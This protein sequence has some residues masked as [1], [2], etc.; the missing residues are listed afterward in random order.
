MMSKFK[1]TAVNPDGSEARG[2]IEGETRTAAGL[3]LLERDLQITEMSEHKSILQFELIRKKVPRKDLMQFSR[4]MAVFLRAG[5]P[6]T[7]ALDIIREEAP[8]KS[9]FAAVLADMALALRG[10]A[11]FTESAMAHPEAFPPFYLGVLEAAEMTGNLDTALEEVAVYIERDLEARRK[12]QSALFYPAVVFLMSIATVLILTTFVLPRFKTF[13][14]DMHAKLPLPTRMLLSMTDFLTRDWPFVVGT[15]LIIGCVIG[16][17]PRTNRGRDIRD[18]LLLKT[19]VI[20]GLIRGAII[21]RF[22]RTL[23]SMVRSGVS[24]PDALVVTSDGTNNVIYRRGLEEVRMSMLQGEGLAGPIARTGLFPGA[25]RQM[26]RVGEETGTLD[27]QLETS[28]QYFASDLDFKIARFTNLFEPAVILFMGLVVGFVAI[29]LVS[30]M[31][32]IFNQV[33]IT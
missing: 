28:A 17:G 32:G 25:A 15:L 26:I 13:F 6:V 20:G 8:P 19:P 18:T 33:N 21:E 23:S 30:A 4:Q 29:A 11:T 14:S 22:C 5:I 31:Y 24:L 10:G 3:A 12:I 7:D 2:V 16:F 1:Y 9:L 27:K